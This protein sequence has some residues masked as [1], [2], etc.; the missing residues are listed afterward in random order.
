M[1]TPTLPKHGDPW[2]DLLPCVEVERA[3]AGRGRAGRAAGRRGRSHRGWGGAEGGVGGAE[4][5]G[6]G[7]DGGHGGRRC[8]AETGHGLGQLT[9][10]L[11]ERERWGVGVV[12]GLGGGGYCG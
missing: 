2:G 8:A 12:W 3:V 11:A 4:A 6:Q 9:G 7:A 5:G 1:R 10:H